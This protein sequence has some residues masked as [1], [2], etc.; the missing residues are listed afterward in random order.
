[1]TRILH[2]A[3]RDPEAEAPAWTRILH[4]ALR[5]PEAEAPA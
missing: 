4:V 5:D 1:M 3:L 2:V